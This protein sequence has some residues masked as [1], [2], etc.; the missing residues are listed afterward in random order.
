[1]TYRIL[2]ADDLAEDG[3]TI[4]RTAGEVTVQKGMNEDALRQ[5]LPGFHALVVRSATQVTARSLELADD[6]ALVHSP[7]LP[8]ACQKPVSSRLHQSE[9]T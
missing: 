9:S 5:K 1:M 8:A 2:V 6:L 7:L 3:L 4:L